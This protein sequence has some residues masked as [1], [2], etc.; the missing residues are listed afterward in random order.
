MMRK[1]LVN[2]LFLSGLTLAGIPQLLAQSESPTT[3]P[4]KVEINYARPTNYQIADITVTGGEGYDP[5]IL[6]NLS[7][8]NVGDFVEV[9]GIAF[10]DAVRRF[11]RNGY[12]DNARIVANKIEGNKIWL[13][14]QLKQ[15]PKISSVSFT[16][17]SK[18]ERKDLEEKTGLH[19]EMQLTPNIIDRTKQLVKKYFDE[20]GYSD[21]TVEVEQKK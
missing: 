15:R 9:P 7:G 1:F 4:D 3:P 2:I 18:S 20:K 10:S 12:F 8:L 6:I 5:A 14:I 11:M 17:V 19:A 21:M 13:E 16:G